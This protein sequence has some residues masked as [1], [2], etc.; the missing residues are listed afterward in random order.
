MVKNSFTRIYASNI[1]PD[2]A[3]D[4]LWMDLSEDPN[5]SVIKFW[6]GEY[7]IPISMGNAGE[8]GNVLSIIAN[9][10]EQAKSE[11]VSISNTYTDDQIAIINLDGYMT[12]DADNSNVGILSFNNSYPSS[13]LTAGQLSWD[14]NEGTLELGMNGGSVSQSIGLELMYRVN[15][16]SSIDIVDGDLVSFSGT[17][18]NSGRI[19]VVKTVPGSNPNH[20]LGI[21]TENIFQGESGFVTWFGKVRGV[22]SNGAN[23]SETWVSGDLLYPHP[24]ISGRL[25]KNEPLIGSKMAIAAVISSH[26]NNGSI[27]VRV[28]RSVRLRD[29]DD[30]DVSTSTSGQPLTKMSNGSWKGSSSISVN[31]INPSGLN[32]SVPGSTINASEINVDNVVSEAITAN[33]DIS[34]SGYKI[35]SHSNLD[36]ILAGGGSKPV[37]DFQLKSE[38]S[39][40]NGYASLDSSGLVPTTQLPSFVDDV[41]EFADLALFPNPGETGKIYVA[42]DTNKTYR[43]S[44]SAYIYITSGAVDSVAGKTGVVTLDKADVGLGNV[45]NTSDTNKPVST[46]QAAAIGTK[47]GLTGDETIAGVKAFSSSPIVPNPT[48]SGQ[49]MNK[50]TADGAYVALAGAQNIVGVKTFTDS[51]VVPNPVNNGDAANKAYVQSIITVGNDTYQE[52]KLITDA[53]VASL[54]NVI[55]SANLNQETTTT[56]TGIDTVSL[57]KT[58]ANGGMQVQMF[59]QSAQNLVVNGDFR[60]GTTGWFFSNVTSSL[61][62]GGIL[63]QKTNTESLMRMHTTGTV[64]TGGIYYSRA[65]LKCSISPSANDVMFGQFNSS[66]SVNSSHI[67]Y[68]QSTTDLQVLSIRGTMGQPANFFFTGVGAKSTYTGTI[69]VYGIRVIN[70]TA[71]FGAGNEPTKEQCDLL[72]ANYFE[73]SKNILGTGRMR[74]IGKNLLDYTKG[75]NTANPPA[76]GTILNVLDGNRILAY[77]T[78]STRGRGY[79]VNLLPNTSYVFSA[80]G[81][82]SADGKTPY[83]AI[84]D[85]GTI[86][87]IASNINFSGDKSLLFTTGSTGRVNIH[88]FINGASTSFVSFEN[89]Q[90]ERNII[91]TTYEP[92]RQSAL[93]LTTSELR[94]NGTTKDEIRKGTNGYELVKRVGV[95]TLGS[96]LIPQPVNFTTGWTR[97]NISLVTIDSST[98]FTTTGTAGVIR[99]G[100][101]PGGNKF[102]RVKIKGSISTG[103]LR[104]RGSSSNSNA[105]LLTGTFDTFFYV[106]WDTQ[107]GFYLLALNAATV[108][109]Q[110]LSIKEVI[111]VEA[112]LNPSTLTEIGGLPYYTL[113][114][115][116]ITPI[117]HAGLLNSNSNG[118]VYFEPVVADAGVYGSNIAI[119]LTD[120][121]ISSFESIRKYSG[122]TYTE[123]NT[124]AAVIASGG[125]S[126]THPDL[127]SGDLVLFTYYYNK[128]SINR[129]MTVTHYDSRHVNADTVN[130]KFYRIVPVVTN[131]V[132]SW[133]AVEV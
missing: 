99:S 80:R 120:Y 125:L 13:N 111:P 3:I 48:T 17:D 92:F 110:E 5:G 66:L 84:Y 23:V 56:A 106:N 53:R 74:S 69:S 81:Y 121:P 131:G 44:G 132:V 4:V 40:P 58:A 98:Q 103:T 115:P 124:A 54:E 21:A 61:L 39:Q 32:L 65:L 109:I 90:L 117:A 95:G 10:I 83:V 47:V 91:A 82:S 9:Q 41:L 51:P 88:F 97:D 122:G 46:L 78:S 42:L 20:I 105:V 130:G 19:N 73:G 118:T 38:K 64:V 72:F 45:D 128:E 100:G 15:N 16:K 119:Q 34:A 7:Y 96:E 89:I 87:M 24:S 68:T 116:V 126:F 71:T 31:E 59:G 52:N 123:L 26:H 22:Q 79:T 1:A 12:V 94:S 2:P 104:V 108:I 57:P 60:N 85:N 33:G 101:L 55:N 8:L 28:Q 76:S 129:S 112:I 77:N 49:A 36:V 133:T 114:T 43:W 63:M 35:H 29:I 25:T 37:S 67:S 107:T 14:S 50:G 75:Y 30:V 18:G 113:A 11:A 6:N 127:V 62:T 93:Y 70:L 27:F 86:S 102:V